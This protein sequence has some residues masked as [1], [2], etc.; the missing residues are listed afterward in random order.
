MFFK[1]SWK[2]KSANGYNCELELTLR[3]KDNNLLPPPLKVGD[4]ILANGNNY[5][6]IKAIDSNN[7]IILDRPCSF[8]KGDIITKIG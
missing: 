5:Y 3:D 8:S 6:Q 7:I 1:D 2:V 4:Y